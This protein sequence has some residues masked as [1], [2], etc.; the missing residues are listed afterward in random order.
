MSNR[1]EELESKVAE[2]ES[3]VDG[4][5]E[6]LVEAKERIRELEAELESDPSSTAPAPDP[7]SQSGAGD[8]QSRQEFEA[9]KRK[10][11]QA[12]GAEKGEFDGM[13]L[14]EAVEAAP[15]DVE[16]AA[17]QADDGGTD[18]SEASKEQATE[19]TDETADHERE[20]D[21]IIA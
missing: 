3:T 13:G 2:L 12:K 18:P 1:V 8:E 4:L 14:E 21:I 10:L 17:A 20:G 9:M 5:T 11:E 7:R 16:A 19:Q 6:E 15:E